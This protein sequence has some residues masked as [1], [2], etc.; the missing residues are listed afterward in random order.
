MVQIQYIYIQWIWII[1]MIYIGY[2]G[3]IESFKIYT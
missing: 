3:Y 2:I 1:Q